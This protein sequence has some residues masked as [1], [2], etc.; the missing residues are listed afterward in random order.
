M[1][2]IKLVIDCASAS[3]SNAIIRSV[4]QTHPVHIDIVLICV[5]MP[6][7]QRF[8]ALFCFLPQKPA[9]YQILSSIILNVFDE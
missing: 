3:W 6:E 5:T 2:G 1:A 4:V 7:W 8:G 9:A